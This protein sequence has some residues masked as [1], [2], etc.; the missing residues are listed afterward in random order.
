MGWNEAYTIVEEQI[1]NLY[2]LGVLTLPVLDAL[3]E[4][5]RDTDID[6]GGSRDLKSKDGKG[7]ERIAVELIRPDFKP[8]VPDEAEDWDYSIHWDWYEEFSEIRGERWGWS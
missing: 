3:C 8:N 6:S 2:D 5:F 7:M 1:V 4:P